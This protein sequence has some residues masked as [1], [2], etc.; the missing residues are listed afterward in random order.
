[1]SEL[2]PMQ[3]ACW[4][5]RISESEFL[6]GVAAHL[7]VEFDG[8]SI[9]LQ[10]L[11]SALQHMHLKHSIL[12]MRLSSDG[13]AT[14]AESAP[15]TLLEIDDLSVLTP[16]NQIQYLQ[17]KREQWTHQQLDLTSGQTARY[18]SQSAQSIKLS[19]AY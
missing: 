5:G 11:E 10:K 3:A 9:D 12:R 14:I 16:Q 1:M 2:T 18:S 4:F 8:Q 17:D 13:I 7:Y 6:G 15:K 19:F